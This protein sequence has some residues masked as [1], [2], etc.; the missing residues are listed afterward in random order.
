MIMEYKMI[1]STD[2]CHNKLTDS[3]SKKLKDLKAKAKAQNN[4]TP[5]STLYQNNASETQLSTVVNPGNGIRN[6]HSN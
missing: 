5:V 3:Q 1:F 2:D 6:M 4:N